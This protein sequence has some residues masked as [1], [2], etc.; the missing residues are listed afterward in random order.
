MKNT[1]NVLKENQD[2]LASDI[3]YIKQ[4]FGVQI[5]FLG[6]LLTKV[7]KRLEEKDGQNLDL[8]VHNACQYGFGN[9]HQVTI[10]VYF[11]FMYTG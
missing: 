11:I 7:L 6:D 3:K 2:K 4:V 5:S 10:Y 1:L 9:M 8:V